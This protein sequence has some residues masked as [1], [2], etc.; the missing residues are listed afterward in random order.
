MAIVSDKLSFCIEIN[1]CVELHDLP[2]DEQNIVKY[3]TR[4]KNGLH[5][6]PFNSTEYCFVP[7]IEDIGSVLQL[8]Y[9]MIA[10]EEKPLFAYKNRNVA[11]ILKDSGIPHINLDEDQFNF[12]SYREIQLKY[13]Q[14]YLCGYHKPFSYSSPLKFKCAY[15]KASQI[16][17]EI[18]EKT[19]HT[20]NNNITNGQNINMDWFEES[21]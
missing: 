1:P 8:L 18:K 17:K 9:Q 16:F 19:E 11:K 21:I 6:K 14:N 10:S 20:I 4:N 2:K 5:L 12:P 15:R 13:A 3:I 7:K